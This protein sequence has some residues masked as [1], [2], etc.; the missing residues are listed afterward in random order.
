M[1]L[2]KEIMKPQTKT[3][4]TIILPSN[5]QKIRTDVPQM[6]KQFCNNYWLTFQ[7]TVCSELTA[8]S[9]HQVGGVSCIS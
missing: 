2:A 3:T 4:D 1:I 9:F 5:A 6:C 7:K 8:C